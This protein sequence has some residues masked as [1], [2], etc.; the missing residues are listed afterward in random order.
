[1]KESGNLQT[2]SINSD[3]FLLDGSVDYAPVIFREH[4]TAAA[5][6][7]AVKARAKLYRWDRHALRWNLVH[8]Q[9]QTDILKTGCLGSPGK[10][11]ASPY[12]PCKC[13]YDCLFAR[14]EE[15]FEAGAG[16]VILPERL[17]VDRQDYHN[18][19]KLPPCPLNG[20]GIYSDE[21]YKEIDALLHEMAEDGAPAN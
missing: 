20:Y 13:R 19:E 12:C 5:L 11:P 21:D 14:T 7:T 9:R 18:S 6:A 16:T 10:C 8:I 2:V 1:M 15:Y 17:V 3:L 4:D